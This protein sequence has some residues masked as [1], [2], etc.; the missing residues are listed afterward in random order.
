[1]NDFLMHFK[2]QIIQGKTLA[3]SVTDL[4]IESEIP[5]LQQVCR[6]IIK[7]WILHHLSDIE[8]FF[9]KMEAATV[10]LVRYPTKKSWAFLSF[11][12]DENKTGFDCSSRENQLSWGAE[13]SNPVHITH[14]GRSQG[15]PLCHTITA[16]AGPWRSGLTRHSYMTV[17]ES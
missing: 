10:F 4:L 7:P 11:T 3:A 2:F 8:V 1:M 17:R 5:L 9:G 12:Q 16:A 15:G 6:R 13:I 14:P